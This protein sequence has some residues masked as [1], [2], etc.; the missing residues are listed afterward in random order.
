[1]MLDNVMDR[2]YNYRRISIAGRKDRIIDLGNAGAFNEVVYRNSNPPETCAIGNCLFT[3]IHLIHLPNGRKIF[4]AYRSGEAPDILLVVW[5]Y[6]PFNRQIEEGGDLM[7]QELKRDP[8]LRHLMVDNS[9]VRSD[10]LNDA[11]GEYLN[12]A[13]M[14]GLIELGLKGF[15]HL[16]AESYL[17]GKSF[18]QFGAMVSA[19]IAAIADK[20]KREPFTYVPIQTS[21]ISDNGTIDDALRES[22]LRKGADILRSLG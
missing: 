20:L 10:W 6:F 5:K 19:N 15:T 8:H 1:M 4:T 3:S 17:G 16:Q 7:L 9:Y 12:N 2:E 14:P 22:A 11:T 13:W 21:G 18:D